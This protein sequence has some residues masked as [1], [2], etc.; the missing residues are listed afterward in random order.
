VG[1]AAARLAHG[2]PWQDGALSLPDAP[3]LGVVVDE[4]MLRPLLVA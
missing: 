2:W 4:T 3:C 1:A